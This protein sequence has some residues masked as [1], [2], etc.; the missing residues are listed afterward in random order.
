M[1]EL[2][3]DL[4]RVT[5]FIGFAIGIGAAVFLEGLVLSR[6]RVAI[7]EEELALIEHGHRLILMA[8]GVLWISGLALVGLKTGFDPAL[9][10]GKMQAKMWIVA[11]LTANAFVIAWVVTPL[12]RDALYSSLSDMH[13]MKLAMIGGAAG[14]SAAGW[15]S[16]LVL[17]A[18]G[19]LAT[20]QIELLGPVFFG[21]L[22]AGI[23]VGAVF[24]VVIGRHEPAD[25]G[26]SLAASK[27]ILSWF[28]KKP[29]RRAAFTNLPPA[30]PPN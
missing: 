29:Q 23:L 15:L 9:I 26:K 28:R 21:V 11:A 7:E 25:P 1:F 12:L 13:D 6:A 27:I 4:V 3:T 17:G 14:L 24:A 18:V 22:V 16:A 20:A 30:D 19:H 10:T 8:L 5:H 2:F